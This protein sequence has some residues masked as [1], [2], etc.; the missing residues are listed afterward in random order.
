MSL[1]N[2]LFFVLFVRSEASKCHLPFF[3]MSHLKCDCSLS[4]NYLY[5][6]SYIKPHM[7]QL[8]S[9]IK[10]VSYSKLE[11]TVKK[12]FLPSATFARR[13]NTKSRKT[14]QV[15]PLVSLVHFIK[16]LTSKAKY[17]LDF[18]DS[19]GII[20]LSHRRTCRPD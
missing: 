11:V 2:F 4:L 7:F 6:I 3:R 18:K 10:I 1:H 16:V 9:I 12:L 13:P 8:R 14:S 17:G 20:C 15:F 5:R 19:C